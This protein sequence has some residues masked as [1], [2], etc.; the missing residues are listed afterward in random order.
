[1][2]LDGGA[3]PSI[4]AL[5]SPADR[6]LRSGIPVP[7]FRRLPTRPANARL[8]GWSPSAGGWE[9][10]VDAAE[11]EGALESGEG[12]LLQQFLGRRTGQ[13]ESGLADRGAHTDATDSDGGVVGDAGS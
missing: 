9:Q 13:R 6:A 12:A 4:T 10:R 8:S 1:M 3:R 11:V 5:S 7:S 2:L